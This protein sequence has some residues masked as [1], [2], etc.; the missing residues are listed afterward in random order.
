MRNDQPLRVMWL[1]NHTS[2]R[3]FEIPMLKRIGVEQIFQP[4]IFPADPSFRSA[5]VDFSEDDR[6]AI[7]VHDLQVLNAADWYAGAS[8]DAWEIANRHFDVVFLILHSAEV[9][10]SA[11]K[12]FRGAIVL[13]AFGTEKPVTYE[14]IIAHYGIASTVRGL[15]GRFYFGEAYPHLGDQEA[16][17]LRDR[18]C[19]LPLGM[20][21]VDYK[22]SWE[23]AL[24]QVIF[25]CPDIGFN[26]Y[27]RQIYESFCRSFGDLPYIVAGAQPIQVDD[28]RV[29][30]F[31][32][33]EQHAH[34][35]TQ[36]RVMFYHSQES[37][38]IHYHPFEAVRIGMPLVFMG[39]GMLDRMGGSKL[40]G[41]C[42][43]IREARLKIERILNDDQD[44]IRSIRGSQ[45]L[46]LDAMNPA[47]CEDA[48]QAGFAR[49]AS[50]LALARAEQARRPLV[51]KRKRIAVILPVGYRGGSLRGALLLAK[52]LYIGSRQAG[53]PTD[54]VFLHLDDPAVYSTTDF[55]DLAEGVQRRPYKW[56]SLRAGEAR[57]AMRYAGFPEWE[58]LV[59]QYLVPD[60]GIQQLQDCDLWLV[61]SDRLSSPL[62]PLKPN[63]LMVYDYLQRY[64]AVMPQGADYFFLLAAQ[65]AARVLV[66]TDFTWRDATQYAGLQPRLVRRVPMLAPEFPIRRAAHNKERGSGRGYFIWTTN[67]SLHKNH[68]RAAQALEIYY[69]ELGGNLDCRVTG[70]NTR[71][72]LTSQTPHLR[73]M[74][75]VFERSELLKARVQWCGELLDATYR[76]LVEGAVF[77]W[78]A[79][80]IDNGTFSVIEAACLGVPSLSSDYPAMREMDTQFALNLAWMDA[81]SPRDMAVKLK[82]MESD[83]PGR[84]AHLPS[85]QQLAGQSVEAL[86]RQYWEEVRSCL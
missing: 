14:K 12:Y 6:L 39:G 15:G 26:F 80:N 57:R 79:G 19:Y 68:A 86:A 77:L 81:K 44:L 65:S 76:E 72:M 70:V 84:R 41:R 71:D 78:H 64:E 7:S 33:N 73:E 38:H 23:G 66:T 51:T 82:Q 56:K 37:H 8:Q 54:V 22:D 47:N 1:L 69:G 11:A 27:Y 16:K 83:A 52:A 40:P 28:P 34:N 45:T 59:Q 25:V 74:A 60:D 24:K 63:V 31:V 53:E 36:S 85:P 4:K 18:R 55:D 5:N 32:S 67:A 20:E 17:Y 49:I 62:L 50:E 9:L 2:A 58:P 48:W 21:S 46:L 43:T 29:L 61:V 30:G 35:M 3:K 42:E 13:R 10:V 75:K